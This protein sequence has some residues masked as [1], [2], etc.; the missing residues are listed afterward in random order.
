MKDLGKALLIFVVLSVGT[1]L[2]Y[3]LVVTGLSQWLF[4]VQANGSQV[5][6]GGR[7]VGSSLIGQSNTSPKYFNGRPS[8][9][10]KPYDASNS[11]GS[12]FGPTNKKYLEQVESRIKQ[13]RRD[14]GLAA[15]APVPA[16]LVL[17]SASGLDPDI[18]VDAAL[19]Q[20]PRIA[21]VRGMTED[22][23]RELVT[24][25]VEG[26]YWGC[27]KVNVLGLNMALDDSD[28]K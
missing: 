10:E 13:V 21:R 28:K 4:P 6:L 11:G 22:K 8:A 23:V 25:M 16:D 2:V 27:P 14:N 5:T 19:L 17:A 3:P 7:L 12:N 18:S 9:L 24:G 15:D 26:Q 20:V 1:G